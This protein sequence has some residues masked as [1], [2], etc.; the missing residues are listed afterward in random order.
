MTPP[1][2]KFILQLKPALL[3]L[4]MLG[5][6]GC[7]NKKDG[8]AGRVYHNM[9][10]HYNGYFN[11]DE[12]VEKGEKTIR[13]AHKDDYD[14]LL[15][16]FIYGTDEQAKAT[17]PD[18]EKAI[19]K[20]EKVINK[21][22]IKDDSKKDKKR[23]ELN[24]WID[25]NYMV[26]GRA[27]FY[28]RS[29]Y[30]AAD[31]F[32][33][34]NRKFKKPEVGIVSNSWLARTY[35]QQEEYSKAVQTL[36]KSENDAESDKVDDKLKADY[37]LVFADALIH[38][39]KLE[40][41]AEQLEKAIGYTKRKKDRARPNYILAQIYQELK[42]SSDAITAYETVIHS[43]APYELEFHARIN[44]ALSYSRTG[45]S[46][47]QIQKEL[48][49]M[50][51]DEKNFDYRDQ[52]YYALGDIA[53]E[54][55]RRSDAIYFYEQSLR[56]NT[57]NERQKAKAFLRLA[58]LYFDERQYASAQKYYDSTLTT[59]DQEND[60]FNIIKARAESLTELVASLDA[61]ELNDSLNVICALSPKEQEKKL[62]EIAKQLAAEKEQQR[63][64]DERRAEEAKKSVEQTGVTGTFWCYNENLKTKGKANFDETWGGRPLKD[65]WRLQS[66]LAES[67][68]PGEESEGYTEAAAGDSTSTTT[69]DKYK[70][71][72]ADELKAGLPCDNNGR[73]AEIKS[74]AAEGY[75]NAGV[76]YKEKLDDDDNAI[77]TWEELLANMD[78]SDYHPTTYYQLFR[79]W[80]AKEGSKGYVKNPFCS[81]CNSQYW[82]DEIKSRYPGSDWAMLVDNPAFLDVQD[83]KNAKE[84]EIYQEA[85]TMY[86]SRNYTG[87]KTFCDS[88][89]SKEPQNHL[90]CKY[91]LLRAV[92][93]GY[94]DA[95]Y[96]VKQN[97]QNELNQ[98]VQTCGGTEEANRAQELLNALIKGDSS[99]NLPPNKTDESTGEN[100]Q[101]QQD[102][103]LAVTQPSAEDGPYKFDAN[104]EHYFAIILPVKNSD[105]NKAKTA[106]SDFNN[107]FFTSAQLKVTNNLLDKDNHLVLV[108][109]FK[110][111]EDSGNY[112]KAFQAD[113]DKLAE[114]NNA[115]YRTFLISKQNYIALFKNKDLEQ[116]MDFY[117][118]YYQQP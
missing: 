5:L 66:K 3:I 15:P 82:G 12:L 76:I 112:V 50:L 83:M 33:Y 51:K 41:A 70:A 6:W 60:R 52:I 23:P 84:N 49:K 59:I 20:C 104:A 47:A 63:I 100:Q 88:I 98:L 35:I 108:K 56:N 85:Y 99:Q 32:Q 45:G 7:S 68:G 102:S 109:S 78:D 81:T 86:S 21:H 17:F 38:Q 22:T 71:P 55:Q 39:K 26:V 113:L 90:L 4:T 42:R 54:E 43:H 105:V 46:S 114:I 24:K 9:T 74:S 87:A 53:W 106:V 29:Y 75:Y 97:Y 77:S 116:Y 16:I 31:I 61:I 40:K 69:N 79:T 25:E 93:V 111:Q 96:G 19:A 64:E 101:N 110:K 27:H 11:A 34:V 30:K 115:G 92:C 89:I 80:L 2:V 36:V 48:M 14:K 44:K 1:F 8:T 72:T 62:Q 118:R 103:S 13:T 37:H 58:D 67:F 18:M 117:M 95:L 91:K 57:T 94:S 10:A 65:Y 28:K 73:M 107:L